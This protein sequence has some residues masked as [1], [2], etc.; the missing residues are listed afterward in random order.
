MSVSLPIQ[1]LRGD[2]LI[3]LKEHLLEAVKRLS[4][5]LGY[6]PADLL[7]QITESDRQF[8]RAVS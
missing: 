3:T 4:A 1:R 6:N 7:P 5:E 8:S 2:N